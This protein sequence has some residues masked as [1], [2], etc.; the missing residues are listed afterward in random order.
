[1]TNK[2]TNIIININNNIISALASMDTTSGVVVHVQVRARIISLFLL[3]PVSCD[4]WRF[5]LLAIWKPTLS[6][7][8]PKVI[9]GLPRC[10]L[11]PFKHFL[12]QTAYQKPREG[13]P[14]L[15]ASNEDAAV[16]GFR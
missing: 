7:L 11:I 4:I 13:D 2:Q 5:T 1:M 6:S 3:L 14:D 10:R 9:V 16:I 8:G 15:L 12:T